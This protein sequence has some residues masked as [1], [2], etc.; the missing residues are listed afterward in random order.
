MKGKGQNEEVNG[1]TKDPGEGMLDVYLGVE[2]RMKIPLGLVLL[3]EFVDS[4]PFCP[5]RSQ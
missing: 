5:R 1:R 3:I 2:P 4:E